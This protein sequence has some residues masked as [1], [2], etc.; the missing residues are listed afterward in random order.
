MLNP[1]TSERLNRKSIYNPNKKTYFLLY[2]KPL[3]EMESVGLVVTH[4][5]KI[6]RFKQQSCQKPY[7][8][9]NINKRKLAKSK[10]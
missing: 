9:F 1:L 5:Q 2:Y 7:I 8:E 10:F 4:Y 6:L 3:E